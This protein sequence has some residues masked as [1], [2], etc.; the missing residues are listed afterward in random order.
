[1]SA[2]VNMPLVA[3]FASP[4]RKL[5]RVVAKMAVVCVCGSLVFTTVRADDAS[6]AIPEL[7]AA[8]PEALDHYNRG[9]AHYRAGRYEEAVIELERALELDPDSPDL[10]YNLA[11]VY[12]LLGNIDPSIRYYERYRAMLPATEV[13]ERE[14]VSGTIERLQGARRALPK[15]PKPSVPPVVL[16]TERGVADGAFWTLASLSLA[17]LAAGTATG[18]LALGAED[19]S[20]Q[21]VLGLDGDL[22]DRKQKDERANKLALISDASMAVGAIGGLTS[23]LLYALRTKPVISPGISLSQQAVVFSIRG[24][25]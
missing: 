11:R 6:D 2:F 1:V 19:D 10:V 5:V 7:R 3:A 9:R 4:A 24:E 23:I 17:A 20:K 15:K 14:R 22:G 13:E 8:P 16:R 18:V 21:F 12:E 25:L